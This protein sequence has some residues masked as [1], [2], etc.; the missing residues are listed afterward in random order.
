VARERLRAVRLAEHV[1]LPDEGAQAIGVLGAPH[2]ELGRELAESGVDDQVRKA[3]QVRRG[4]QHHVGAEAGEGAS[5]DRARDHAR[6]VEHADARERA[7]A[8]PRGLRWGLADLLDLEQRQRG[9][10][11][12]LRVRPP[13][14]A[15]AD[16]A[17]GQPGRG[18][19]VL[20]ILGAPLRDRRR[21]RIA[22]GPAAQDAQRAVPVVGHVRVHLDEAPVA[23]A[24]EAEERVAAADGLAVDAQVSLAPERSERGARVDRHGLGPPRPEPPQLGR[25]QRG[26]RDHG[27]RRRADLEVR[28]HE[29]V[30]AG[31]G[32]PLEGARVAA[33]RAPQ[34]VERG[35]GIAMHGR[36]DTPS[37][38]GCR[39]GALRPPARRRPGRLRGSS[40]LRASGCGASC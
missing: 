4:D 17:G 15:R 20:E 37:A 27:G 11:A 36:G 39:Q 6:E 19:R 9:E 10:G 22:A 25:G 35:L 3:R 16:H 28:R 8:R 2:V 26:R 5:A 24:V 38:R 14:L 29:R 21:D 34:P 31:Q 7:R 23:R 18:Q 32:G 40:P 12:P 13:L 30:R 1:G 33:G